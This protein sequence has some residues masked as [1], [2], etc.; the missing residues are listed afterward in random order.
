[1]GP[2]T[3]AEFDIAMRLHLDGIGALLGSESGN[4]IVK[5]IVPGGAAAEDGRL[6]PND[7]I[8]G[9]AQGD[10]KFTDVIDMKLSDVV[11]M[12]RGRRG[13]KVQLKV[14]PADKIEPVVL[15]FTRRNIELKSQE[16]RGE[17]VDQGKKADGT[18]Y[19]IGVIDLPS[20]YS[21]P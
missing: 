1:M 9:V 18:P 19:K 2:T 16:A 4:T 14:V 10:D 11:K 3:L 20:F 8:I 7:K 12:I 15:T 13:T 21:D 17:I 6:K 5:E